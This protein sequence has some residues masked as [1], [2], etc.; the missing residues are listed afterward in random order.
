MYMKPKEILELAMWFPEKWWKYPYTSIQSL[1]GMLHGEGQGTPGALK[2]MAE[3]ISMAIRDHY[4]VPKLEKGG[5]DVEAA[6]PLLN[7]T[8]STERIV[9]VMIPYVFKAGNMDSFYMFRFQPKRMIPES[10]DRHSEVTKPQRRFEVTIFH[11]GPDRRNWFG[12]LA[13]WLVYSLDYQE[14]V[15]L[16]G[17]WVTARAFNAISALQVAQGSD[18]QGILT[19][20]ARDE[21]I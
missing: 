1:I 15:E 7:C 13:A 9:T 12:S 19:D 2:R 14:K 17:D 11:D 21:E 20:M 10:G 3:D 8:I 6:R 5:V 16:D 4:I 18:E